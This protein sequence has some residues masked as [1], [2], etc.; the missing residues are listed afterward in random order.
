MSIEQITGLEPVPEV[1]KT[2]VPPTTPHLQCTLEQI[3][4]AINS[5]EVNCPD[6]LNDESKCGAYEHRTHLMSSLQVK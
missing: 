6:P 1:W 2:P 5:L 3:R 4:T